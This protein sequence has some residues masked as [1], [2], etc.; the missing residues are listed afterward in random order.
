MSKKLIRELKYARKELKARM[1]VNQEAKVTIYAFELE[2]A[3]KLLESLLK[4]KL[5]K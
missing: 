5:V 2:A 1:L 3:F 4:A